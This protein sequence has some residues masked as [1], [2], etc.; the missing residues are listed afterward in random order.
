MKNRIL[1]LYL[2]VTLLMGVLSGCKGNTQ[3]D[4]GTGEETED[5]VQIEL[6]EIPYEYEQELN[7]VE[8]EYR[9]FY[10][11]FVYSFY[12]SDGDGI[13]DI[14]G[15]ISKLDYINDGDDST[16]TDLGMNGIW[17]MPIMPSTTYHKY[18]VTDYYS[19]DPE[20]GTIV[21]FE[22]LVKECDKRGITLIIDFVFNHSSAKHP[23]FIQATEYLKSLKEG[24]EP[25]AEECPYIEYYYFSK[26]NKGSSWNKVEG[27]QWYYECM[28][29]DQ[30]PDLALDNMNVRREIE[31]IAEYWLALG[32]DGFRLDAAKEFFSGET[33]KNI[34][35][36]EWFTDYVKGINPEAYIV[37]E[38]WEGSSVIQEY[39]KSGVPSMFNFPVSQTG[40]HIIKAA[41]NQGKP[42]SEIQELIQELYKTGNPN[43][44]DAPFV[45]NHDTTRIS[46]QCVNDEAQMKLAAGLLFTMNGNPFIY[47]GEEIGM[48][49]HGTKDENKRLPMNWSDHDEGITTP[50]A[51]ADMVEQKFPTLE[52]QMKDPL[53]IYHYY[54]R[55]IRIRNENPEIARGE[56]EAVDIFNNE[57][58]CAVK[59]T[60]EG[61]SILIIYN[62]GLEKTQVSITGTEYAEK[63]IRGYLT[64][65]EAGV[66]IDAGNLTMPGQSIVILK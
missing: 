3:I 1:V 38:V 46:A 63:N 27:T 51:Q 40:G 16:H 43:F 42:F 37:A 20:Y 21:D 47:Y 15:I 54:K 64:V 17:L 18:D 58:V 10:E 30:M 41:K 52:E 48:S 62:L 55:G 7:I 61:S 26:E 19:I 14:N 35:V 31:R 65:G 59:K 50:P 2:I 60:W 49:S 5:I 8:D 45:S 11:I 25:D 32:V 56:V 6:V 34:E 12:D 23:W 13:G 9:N 28:F 29:W 22:N 24:E 4:Y 66:T 33:Q 57:G 36:L 39:Y 44:I 53:S